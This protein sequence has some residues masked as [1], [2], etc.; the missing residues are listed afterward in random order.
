MH[1]PARM[2]TM[3]LLATT[4]A[5][6]L[7]MPDMAEMQRTMEEAQ[8]CMAAVDQTALE[9]LGED[10]EALDGE[11][12]RLCAAGRREEARSRAMAFAVRVMENEEARRIRACTEQLREAM[13]AMPMMP[14]API[15]DLRTPEEIEQTHVC[16]EVR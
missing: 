14:A 7:A 16:D 1:G 13:A 3:A 11:L 12:R 15:P 8:R 4:P 6:P 9:Q 10:A 5:V 2:L